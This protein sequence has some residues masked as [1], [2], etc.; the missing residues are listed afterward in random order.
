MVSIRNFF[1]YRVLKSSFKLFC[2]I[3]CT[4][5]IIFIVKIDYMAC[6]NSKILII[7]ATGYLGIFM[8]K[9]SVSMGHS[10]FAFT[11]P[12]RS[13]DKPSKLQLLSEF[14]SMGVTIFQV[15]VP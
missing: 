13:N 2:F 4:F 14:D 12:F 7:G 11:R 6:E 15:L 8:V 3:L 9:A 5:I 10:T 1:V